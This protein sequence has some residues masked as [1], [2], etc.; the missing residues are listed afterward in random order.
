MYPDLVA[1]CTGQFQFLYR[2]HEFSIIQLVPTDFLKP[3][4]R[5]ESLVKFMRYLHI[6]ITAHPLG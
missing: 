4:F 5:S 3:E 1:Q 6:F 2:N